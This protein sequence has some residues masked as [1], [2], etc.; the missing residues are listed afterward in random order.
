MSNLKRLP[1]KTVIDVLQSK[2]HAHPVIE[3]SD[4][5]HS[6]KDAATSLGV[7][8]GAIVKTHL[9][10]IIYYEKYL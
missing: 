4:T 3:L 8:V 10:I 2:R 1:V 6:A 9:F 5:A 7:R